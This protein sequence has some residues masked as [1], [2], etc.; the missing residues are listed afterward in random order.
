MLKDLDELVLKCRDERARAYIGEAVACY[1]TGAYRSAIVSTWI[2]V[3]FDIIDKIYELSVAGDPQAAKYI[4]DYDNYV[5]N[6]NT[7]ALLKIERELLATARDKYELISAQEYSELERLREDRNQCAHPS[8]STFPDVFSPSPELVRLHIRSA[9]EALLQN[10]PSQGKAALENL[11]SQ[12]SANYFPTTVPKALKV[13]E[14]SP[15]RRARPSL[16]RN[17]LVSCLKAAIDTKYDYKVHERVRAAIRCIK[18]MHP[19]AWLAIVQGELP[20]IM[21]G[22]LTDGG[23]SNTIDLIVLDTQLSD[24]LTPDLITSLEQFLLNRPKDYLV[25]L[26]TALE[27]PRLRLVAQQAIGDLRLSDLEFISIFSSSDEVIERVISGYSQVT[28][29]EEANEWAKVLVTHIPSFSEP[30]A[31]RTL[32][33]AAQNGQIKGSFS[34]ER[35]VIPALAKA[36]KL[37]ETLFNELVAAIRA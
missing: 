23:F 20:R 13:L 17:L 6:K 33:A 14:G 30:Q 1:K 15:L 10:E 25:D 24:A 22:F 18:I 16:V 37:P 7:E 36:K 3:A 32:A 28:S 29:F 26:E 5:A 19:V 9:V 12:I 4:S 8:R 31:R 34:L 35:S 21:R 27:I 2:A 11:Q